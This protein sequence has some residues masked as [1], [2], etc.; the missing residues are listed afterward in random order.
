MKLSDGSDLAGDMKALD[1]G[2]EILGKA[3]GAVASKLR[4]L[5]PWILSSKGSTIGLQA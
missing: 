5:L 3:E 2:C 1:C 4:P